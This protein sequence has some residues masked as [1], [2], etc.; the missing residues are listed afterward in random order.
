[1]VA[2]LVDSERFVEPGGAPDGTD[3]LVTDEV[4]VRRVLVRLRLLD[5]Q[6]KSD[7]GAMLAGFL[8]LDECA[9]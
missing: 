2:C 5:S 4:T 3:A 8:T 1:L 9:S 7:S 6:W